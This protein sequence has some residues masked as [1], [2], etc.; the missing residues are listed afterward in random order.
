M[1][2]WYCRKAIRAR[3]PACSIRSASPGKVLTSMRVT[4]ST[5]AGALS[6][7]SEAIPR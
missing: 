6:V 4:S 1:N 3:S 7:T 2:S 5:N